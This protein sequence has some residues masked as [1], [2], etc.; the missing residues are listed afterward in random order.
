MS[1]LSIYLKLY[2]RNPSI[3]NTV[4]EPIIR[5]F[6]SQCQADGGGNCLSSLTFGPY[7]CRFVPEILF[8]ALRPTLE[9]VKNLDK[10]EAGTILFLFLLSLIARLIYLYEIGS[11]PFFHNAVVDEYIYDHMGM[12]ILQGLPEQDGL[13]RSPLYPMFLAL[14]YG[15]VGHRIGTARIIQM[16]IG[17]VCT[18][19]LYRFS[20]GFL[21][22]RAAVTSA[23]IYALYWP[24]IYFQGELLII[25][26]FS[27]LLLLTIY[28]FQRSLKYG[29]WHV[30]ILTGILLGISCLARG[31]A[32]FIYPVIALY[33]VKAHGR[34][35]G[36]LT[37]ALITL[38]AGAV[39][40][41]SGYRN[42]TRTGEFV[43][44]S[45]NGA[46]NFYTGN[47]PEADGLN[48]VL[49]G[50]RWN[51]MVREPIRKGLTGA[52]EQSK[53]WTRKTVSFIRSQ[54][55]RFIQLYLK[56]CYAFWNALEV[57]NNKDIY[58]MRNLSVFLSLPLFGFGLVGVFAIL[59][60]IYIRKAPRELR[61][62]W[63][64][65][66]AYMAGNAFFFTAARY[67]MA[68]VPFVI[69]L[70]S[71][72]FYSVMAALKERNRREISS[73]L[74]FL[75]A[76]ALFVNTDPLGMR[77][78]IQTRPHFQTGQI[79]LTLDRFDE[80]IHEMETDLEKRPT[81]PDILNN[82]GV[83]YKKKGDFEKARN[84]YEQALLSGEYSGV[85]WNLGL[86]QFETGNYLEARSNWIRALEFDPFN[87]SIR[88][89]LKK[90]EALIRGSG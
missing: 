85:R 5:L 57:S 30:S 21:E 36:V 14:C 88:M 76:A 43:L 65:I 77:A 6:Y 54:P 58:Y 17:A 38:A 42:Y 48:P 52:A 80:A 71:F 70:G 1:L 55:Q 86:L 67:R 69:T 68:V 51:R 15:I 72:S 63:W 20:R 46:I 25:S 11:T 81:D 78:S 75:A 26:I 79:Y 39:L 31:T 64:L 18:C 4:S 12:A 83:V 3:C 37:L 28:V 45:S 66:L 2:P 22:K 90:V 40:L 27:F 34:R 50:L 60:L 84:Y 89:N 24:A 61:I 73:A 23:V 19:V 47:N 44:L 59:S 7:D 29:S 16:V 35:R 13:F 87:P 41:V 10:R 62:L 32:L 9:R 56:K 74:V 49:P 82:L 33:S 53:Y 8:L